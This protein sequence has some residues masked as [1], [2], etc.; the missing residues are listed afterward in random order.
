M[1]SLITQVHVETVELDPT[2]GD[3]AKQCFQFRPSRRNELVVG[4]GMRRVQQLAEAQAASS[5]AARLE[6]QSKYPE[7]PADLSLL[8]KHMIVIDVDSKDLTSGM[9]FPPAAF[10]AKE[11]LQQLKQALAPDGLVVM[12]VACRASELYAG[13]VAQLRSTFAEVH[14]V[15]MA[16]GDVNRIVYAQPPQS[17][18]AVSG[19]G[20]GVGD[21]SSTAATALANLSLP[22]P[23]S[24]DILSSCVSQLAGLTDT[25][26]DEEIDF[27]YWMNKV[28][29]D[30]GTICYFR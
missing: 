17:T 8:S 9:S 19:E 27:E 26:F 16:S 18:G 23:L 4:D 10:V 1:L 13:V 15:S 24:A 3:V 25:P 21:G 7:F 6:L 12:N 14:T 29:L 11:F 5:N 28:E 30:P 20:G 2:V 22:R